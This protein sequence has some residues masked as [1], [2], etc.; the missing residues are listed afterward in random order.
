MRL[1]ERR[2]PIWRIEPAPAR[3]RLRLVLFFHQPGLVLFHLALPNSAP[4]SQL[5]SALGVWIARYSDVYRDRYLLARPQEDGPHPSGRSRI[6]ARPEK[7]GRSQYPPPRLDNLRL[8]DD[9]LGAL[10]PEQRG[11]M[12][13]SMPENGPAFL[14]PEFAPGTGQRRER[15]L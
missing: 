5:G 2:R 12:D 15:P 11:R 10:G 7:Q 4:R 14:R 13:D 3:T 8:H 9:F 6:F 1:G